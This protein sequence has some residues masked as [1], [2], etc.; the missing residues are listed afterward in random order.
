MESLLSD[1]LALLPEGIDWT[2]M[3]TVCL[4]IGGG[5]LLLAVLF[6]IIKGK[7]SDLNHALSSGI[8]IL[9]LFAL[10]VV[11][12]AYAPGE[13][14]A[15]LSPLPFTA[16]RDNC[17]VLFS[18]FGHELTVICHQ[19]L[20]MIILAFLVN[21][22]D[23]QLPTGK[24]LLSWYFFRFLAA[25]LALAAYVTVDRLCNTFLPGV[26]LANAPTILFWVLV[27]LLFLG[28]LKLILGVVLTIANPILGAIY[29][30]FFSN[31]IGKQLTKAVLTT[32][33]LTV[34]VLLL[35]HFGFGIIPVGQ[36]VLISY[37][38]LLGLLL[39]LWYLI[40]HTL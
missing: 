1:L 4:A 23:S 11:I 28:V 21:L 33:I 38:P 19:I 31:K 7:L 24:K 32:V 25:V 10:A 8:S 6:R 30:F 9:I 15:Y 26:L 34:L 17:L 37:I 16:F 3:G 36:A 29:A 22:L 18:F 39:I 35:C 14:S 20:S 27:F 12:H 5:F 2:A 40:G 13:F